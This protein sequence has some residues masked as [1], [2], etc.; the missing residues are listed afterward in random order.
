MVILVLVTDPVPFHFVRLL[1]I[2][3]PVIA[4]IACGTGATGAVICVE[5]SPNL[6]TLAVKP[7]LP[8][9]SV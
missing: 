4:P 9:T 5:P 3:V 1:A 6:M 7:D 8:K 2:P